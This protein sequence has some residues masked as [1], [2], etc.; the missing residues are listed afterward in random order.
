MFAITCPGQGFIRASL[1][2][3]YAQYGRILSPICAAVDESLQASFSQQLNDNNEQFLRK[4]SNA[5]PAMLMATVA[6]A[7][8]LR[9]HYGLDFVSRATAICGHSLG[10]YTAMVL[11]GTLDVGT[12]ARLVRR[13][14]ELMENLRLQDYTMV[15]ALIRPEFL[16]LVVET[17]TAARVLANVNSHKQVVLSGPEST[18][19]N[20]LV[21]LNAQRRVVVRTVKLPVEIPFHHEVLGQIETPLRELAAELVDGFAPAAARPAPVPAP[22]VVCNLTG[23]VTLPTE[24][25]NTVIS[26][27]SRPVQWV[28][29]MDTLAL[30]GVKTLVNFGPGQVLQGINQS[31]PFKNVS[32]DLL[33]AAEMDQLAAV[34]E[35]A[36]VGISP[37]TK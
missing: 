29:T 19:S 18:V 31:F 8:I 24:V 10:E 26:A 3:P 1:M 28:K 13:R 5:Q 37:G 23:A 12:A 14:G 4:T 25:V 35:T 32:A 20:V 36:V 21:R 6:V 33:N 22:A 7:E 15:A 2:S 30:L 27:N 9:S 11:N 34:Y 17:C 16:D